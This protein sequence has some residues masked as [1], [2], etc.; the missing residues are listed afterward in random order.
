MIDKGTA[1]REAQKIGLLTPSL[2]A[3]NIT[4]TIRY[5]RYIQI[6]FIIIYRKKYHR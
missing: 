4:L 6:S 2:S 1:T 5:T 3:K